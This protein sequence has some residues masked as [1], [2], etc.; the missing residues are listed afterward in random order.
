MASLLNIPADLFPALQNLNKIQQEQQQEQRLSLLL[1][2]STST[3]SPTSSTFDGR[4]TWKLLDVSKGVRVWNLLRS[5]EK[6][7]GF[8][9]R[10]TT[11]L[12]LPLASVITLLLDTS[13]RHNWDPL[14][15]HSE[16]IEKRTD[17]SDVVLL[18]Y[19]YASHPSLK[20]TW[21]REYL[22]HR[23]LYQTPSSSSSPHMI[24]TKSIA[25]HPRC[26]QL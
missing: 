1:L 20:W 19:E 26:P 23:Y 9:W 5:E 17:G 4:R 10:A 21:P 3:S 8:V 7:G 22:V 18:R 12:K 16:T 15:S 25:S 14:L 24:V 11:T 6:E 2:E 13:L